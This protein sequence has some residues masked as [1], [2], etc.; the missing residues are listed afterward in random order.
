MSTTE[1]TAV[2]AGTF[3]RPGS[4]TRESMFTPKR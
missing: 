4:R 2:P 1:T 3:G